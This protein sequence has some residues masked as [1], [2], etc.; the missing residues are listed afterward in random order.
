[1]TTG[2]E[3]CG[4]VAETAEGDVIGAE[5]PE[6]IGAA[7]AGAL[8]VIVLEAIVLE[9]I[10]LGASEAM[11]FVTSCG[12]TARSTTTGDVDS[13]CGS[14][15]MGAAVDVAGPEPRELSTTIATPDGHRRSD[16]SDPCDGDQLEL[17]IRTRRSRD[18]VP[19]S[20]TFTSGL[21]SARRVTKMFAGLRSRC[22][23]PSMCASAIASHACNR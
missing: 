2:V 10:V 17:G 19:K 15:A 9:A 11:G 23:M 8:E 6:A 5:A 3:D 20:S 16:D 14:V 4:G 22:T 13:A 1:V 18:G 12:T 21:P 7:E